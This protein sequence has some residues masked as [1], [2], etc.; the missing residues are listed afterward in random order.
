MFRRPAPRTLV[1]TYEPPD[2]LSPAKIRYL[3]KRTFDDRTFWAAVLNLVAKGLATMTSEDGGAVLHLTPVANLK[4]VL[5]D[6]ESLLL[7]H[8]KSQGLRKGTRLS[9][10]DARTQITMS[11]MADL[12]RRES[13]GLWLRENRQFLLVGVVLSSMAVCVA[14]RPHNFKEWLALAWSFA[15]MGPSAY[16]LPFLLLRLRDL[17]RTARDKFD[18]QVMRRAAAFLA[19]LAACVAGMTL[20][21]VELGNIFGWPVLAATAVTT[22]LGIT[23]LHFV[24]TPTEKGQKLLDEIAGFRLFLREVDRYPMNHSEAPHNQ[25]GVYEE[26]LPYAVALE[27]EQAWS[28][29]FLAMTSTFHCGDRLPG[30]ESFYLGMWDG[31]P[32]EIVYHPEARRH[33]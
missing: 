13:L 10:L 1:P 15:V 20:G 12:L 2:K 6:E 24:R 8:L 11:R 23:F 22:A 21:L 7:R 19:W 4:V 30:T 9:V 17:Y 27:V 28:N 18:V 32:I 29:Q 26:F 16:Y 33:Y 3:W 31:K 14:A 5:S 25:P